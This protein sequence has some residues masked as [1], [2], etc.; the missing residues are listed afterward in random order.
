MDS[1]LKK[2]LHMMPTPPLPLAELIGQHAHTLT[3]SERRVAEIVLQQPKFVAF[4]TV[5]DLAH[6]AESGVATVARL[7]SKL[8]FS[9]FSD[10]QNAVRHGLANLLEPA[11]V[12][13]KDNANST[14][15]HHLQMEISNL[16]HTLNNIDQVKLEASI[17][18]LSE[19]KSSIYVISGNASRGVAQ[20]FIEDL[21]ALRPHVYMIEGNPV[22]VARTMTQLNSNDAIVAI[23]LRRYDRWVVEAVE[24]AHER[25][26]KVIAIIDSVLSPLSTLTSQVMVVA[27]A[28]AGPFDSHVGTLALL[29]VLVAGTAE[30]LRRSA[31]SRLSQAEDA[32]HTADVLV[33]R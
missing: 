28:G 20:Q 12:R 14:L 6:A 19:L 8:G 24:T 3:K 16:Q 9:G 33:D 10:M 27:A 13:I 18:Q 17:A 22:Q 26:L 23:D 1:H 4:G 29:N 7:S 31:S 21:S 15:E 32:W 11:A 5:S 30:K 2:V 25:G